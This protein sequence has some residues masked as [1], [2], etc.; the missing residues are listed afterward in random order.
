[1]VP[2]FVEF[3]ESLPRN[4]SGKVDKKKLI[5][6][7]SQLRDDCSGMRGERGKYCK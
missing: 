7:S 5:A 1:M 3:R 6:H 4:A 2:K